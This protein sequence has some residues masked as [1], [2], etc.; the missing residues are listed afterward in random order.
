MQYRHNATLNPEAF[1]E[2]Q[3]SDNRACKTDK[4]EL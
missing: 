1:S 4:N 2:Q 3:K